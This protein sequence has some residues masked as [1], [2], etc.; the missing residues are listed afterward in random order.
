MCADAE[1]Q[2]APA[3]AFTPNCAETV[4]SPL[5][6]DMVRQR[7]E[8]C[9]AAQALVDSKMS[10]PHYLGVSPTAFHTLKDLLE[11]RPGA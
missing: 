5:Y 11:V 2:P 4:D 7:D 3:P 6:R 10:G 1:T 9:A 8:L